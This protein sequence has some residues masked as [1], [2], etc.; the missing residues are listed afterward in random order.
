MRELRVGVIG[1][2]FFGRTQSEILGDLSRVELVAVSDP[3]EESLAAVGRNIVT[4]FHDYKNMF[5]REDT[6]AVHVCVPNR[7]H[8]GTVKDS[9]FAGMD[10]SSSTL[11]SVWVSAN[12]PVAAASRW[13]SAA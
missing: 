9:T 2:G 12:S 6:D 10:V 7:M 4:K 1:C 8:A 11:T 13:N 5:K 3:S